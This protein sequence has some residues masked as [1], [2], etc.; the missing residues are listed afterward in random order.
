MFSTLMHEKHN[1][2]NVVFGGKVRDV[3]PFP[4]T[5][6]II[7]RTVI[8]P[9]EQLQYKGMAGNQVLEWVDLDSEI[10]VKLHL[11]NDSWI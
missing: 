2:K 6:D 7:Y 11:F 5:P 8:Q 1:I 10:K 9:G 4:S 3:P